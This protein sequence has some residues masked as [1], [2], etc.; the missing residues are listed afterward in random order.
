M[1]GKSRTIIAKELDISAN[2]LKKHLSEIYS[3]TINKI[4]NRDVPAQEKLQKL[5][6]FLHNLKPKD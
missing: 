5:T 2:T 6:I 3:K 4:E 1:D